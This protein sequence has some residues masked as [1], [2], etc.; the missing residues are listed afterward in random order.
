MALLFLL[1]CAM[2]SSSVLLSSVSNAAKHRSN[3]EE[4][5]TY[6]DLSSAV[7]TLCDELNQAEYRGRYQ[8]WETQEV[9]PNP[10]DG[11]EIVLTRRHFAQQEGAYHHIGTETAGALEPILRSDFDAIFAQEIQNRLGGGGFT[12]LT[13]KSGAVL[14]HRLTVTPRTGTDLD[15]RDVEI[16]LSVVEDLYTMELTATLD[17]YQIR[18]ELTPITNKPTLPDALSE[19][20][21][22]TEP[23]QWKVGW[24]T[25]GEEEE[26]R[27]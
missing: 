8:Y 9:I 13:V 5:Q 19:G 4:H 17:D 25:T 15:D 18:A 21:Q 3:L 6:L 26:V 1:I 16:S 27:P 20:Q 23:L 2:V 12:T 10:E 24:I 22:T 11:T 14:P 7:S